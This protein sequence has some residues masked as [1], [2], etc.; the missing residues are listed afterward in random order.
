MSVAVIA[1]LMV[2]YQRLVIVNMFASN[3][4]TNV[5]SELIQIKT[6]QFN[7]L[8]IKHGKQVLVSSGEGLRAIGVDINW[9]SAMG[10]KRKRILINRGFSFQEILIC[11]EYKLDNGDNK[12][13]FSGSYPWSDWMI[14]WS[15]FAARGNIRAVSLLSLFAAKSVEHYL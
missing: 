10:E 5:P 2:V 8:M 6:A 4:L 1:S 9:I 7:L 13:V 15:Y 14:V 3:L 12:F 11:Y